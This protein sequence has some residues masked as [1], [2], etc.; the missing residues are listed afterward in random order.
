MTGNN[1]NKAIIESGLKKNFIAK[2]LGIKYDTLRKKLNGQTEF[3]ISE[4]IQLSKILNISMEVLLN[5]KEN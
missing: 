2:Q 1:I 3:K 5:G 4:I